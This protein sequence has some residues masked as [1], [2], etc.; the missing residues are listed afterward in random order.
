MMKKISLA[1]AVMAVSGALNAAELEI[2]LINTTHGI[3]FTP[4]VAAAHNDTVSLFKAGEKASDALEKMA[5]GG[6]IADLNIALTNASANIASGADTEKPG[7]SDGPL[8]AGNSVTFTIS[9][10]AGNDYLSL[11]AM[12]LPTNDGFVGLSNWKIPTEAGTY[13]VALNAYDAGTENNDELDSSIPNA[14]FITTFGN[15]GGNGVVTENGS[16]VVTA[17]D[18]GGVVHIHRG[19]LGDTTADGGISDI[20]STLHRWLNPV[21]HLTVVV[22]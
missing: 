9:T 2:T 12:L 11:A 17:G 5:E 22:K 1:A 3:G 18:E 6:D 7:A 21:A 19:N 10:D 4:V 20:N 14:P 15:P 16:G 8:T 13:R